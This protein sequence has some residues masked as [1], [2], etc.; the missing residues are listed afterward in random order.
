MTDAGALVKLCNDREI[1]E[2]TRSMPHPYYKKDAEAW[3][4]GVLGRTNGPKDFVYLIFKTADKGAEPTLIGGC[5]THHRT[6]QR[7]EIGYWIG[8]PYWL[9]GFATEAVRAMIDHVFAQTDITEIEASA[10]VVNRASQRVLRKC[11]F[12]YVG[13]RMGDCA[14]AGGPVRLN[15]YRLERDIWRSLKDWGNA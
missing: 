12:Q 1:A 7:M 15:Y 14:V 8:K 3:I 2:M 4:G 5:G 6:P 11:G 10:R 9:Q 13:V